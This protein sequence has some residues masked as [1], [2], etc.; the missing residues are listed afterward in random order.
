MTTVCW[1][2]STFYRLMFKNVFT[3][4]LNTILF[5]HIRKYVFSKITQEIYVNH[6]LYVHLE[7]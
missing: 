5:V 2:P 4:I 7:T 1:V 6:M 3:S